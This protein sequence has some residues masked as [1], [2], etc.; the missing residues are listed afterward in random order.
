M[1]DEL[2]FFQS[3]WKI[4]RK[5]WNPPRQENDS[6]QALEFWQCLCQEC[7]ALIHQYDE[8]EIFQPFVKSQCYGLMD[9]VTRRSKIIGR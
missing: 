2:E 5:Y 7:M 4:L 6:P 1:Q 3:W 8:N 9:E